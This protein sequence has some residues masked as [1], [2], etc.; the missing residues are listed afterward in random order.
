MKQHYEDILE[1]V[2]KP[3]I[4][5]TENGVP[6]FHAFDPQDACDI[7]ANEAALVHIECQACNEKFLVC[8]TSSDMKRLDKKAESAGV[9]VLATLYAKKEISFKDILDA[10]EKAYKTLADRIKEGTLRYGDPPNIWCCNTGPTMNSEMISVLEYWYKEQY[11]WKRN[12]EME[13]LLEDGLYRQ[14]NQ[15]KC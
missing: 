2:D 13:V 6:R 9:H 11:K 14:K 7:H 3:V 12:P 10:A 1:A 15:E 8:F 5:W 4:W